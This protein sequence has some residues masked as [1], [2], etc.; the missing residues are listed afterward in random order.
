MG[1]QYIGSDYLGATLNG[2]QYN[3]QTPLIQTENLTVE[4]QFTP[5]D[6]IQVGYVGTQGRHLDI[7]G[8]SN[9]N[10]IILPPGTNTQL[11]IPYP[12]MARNGTYET[13]NANTSYNSMQI[14]YQHQMS[15]GLLVLANYTWSQCA[16][17]QHAPQNSEFN[18][19]YRAEWL[20]G[21]GIKGDYGLCDADAT[22][23]WHAA[24]TYELPFG[25]GKQFGSAMNRAADLIVGGWEING[26]YTFQSGQP[27]TVT[28]PDRHDGRLQLRRQR[29]RRAKSVR[30]P[31]QLHAMVE[32]Q[33]VRAAAQR[34]PRLDRSITR[35]SAGGIQQARGP[36][37]NNLDSSIL[38]NFK[39]TESDD[40][41]SS[42]PNSS[43][44]PTR[45]PS[46]S[47]NS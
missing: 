23:L 46:C 8:T 41:C 26:F 9:S 21:F 47:R 27:F 28:C 25:R 39:F 18:A 19:G 20:A 12:Y 7:L 22:D 29:G 6:A 13:T 2:R 34:L 24:A 16:G 43:T 11:Y 36:H 31:A 3:Y 45:R 33:R 35:R 42:A 14:T 30:R 40:I 4:D 37:F 38:K 15:F 10:S 32:P 5:H 1:G 44:P 17:D